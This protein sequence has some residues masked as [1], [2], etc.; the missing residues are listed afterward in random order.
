MVAQAA[1]GTDALVITYRSGRIQTVPLEEPQGEVQ[2]LAFQKGVPEA[3]GA[4]PAQRAPDRAEA[5]PPPA[6]GSAA[7]KSGVKFEWA[8]PAPE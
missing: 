2:N 1:A 4:Q 8:A 7:P 3:T 6:N 5:A